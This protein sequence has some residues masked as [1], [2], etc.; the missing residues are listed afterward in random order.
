MLEFRIAGFRYKVQQHKPSNQAPEGSKVCPHKHVRQQIGHIKKK[1]YRFASIF[2]GNTTECRML[3]AS[4]LFTN[5]EAAPG[6][7]LV[8]DE[9]VNRIIREAGFSAVLHILHPAVLA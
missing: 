7:E 5:H 4:Q 2:A 1:A 8:I 3:S 9:A 6:S